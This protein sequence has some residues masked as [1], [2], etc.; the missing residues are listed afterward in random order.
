MAS[1]EVF[2][3]RSLVFVAA[4]V[5]VIASFAGGPAT[6]VRVVR[7]EDPPAVP[8]APAAPTADEIAAATAALKTALDADDSSNDSGDAATVEAIHGAAE[9]ADPAIVALLV[10]AMKDPSRAVESAAIEALGVND[11]ADALKAL[12]KKFKNDKALRDDETLFVTLLRAIGRHADDS[13]IAVLLEDPFDHLTLEVGR[14]RIMGLAG[15]RS[16]DAVKGLVSAMKLASP[17]ASRR[18]VGE[19]SE[20]FMGWGRAA[21]TILT[22]VDAGKTKAE[23]V[24]WWRKNDDKF[25]MSAAPPPVPAFARKEWEDFWGEPYKGGASERSVPPG[26]RKFVVDPPQADVDAAVA[27]LQSAVKEGDELAS[28]DAVRKVGLLLSPDAV[29]ALERLH[30]ARSTAVVAAALDAL[31]WMP[32][33]EAVKALNGLYR[34]ANKLRDDEYL[35]PVLLKAIGRHGDPS[36][37]EILT[38]KPLKNLTHASGTARILGLARIRDNDSVEGL[39]KA[40]MLGGNDSR[41]RAT[42]VGAPR[43]GSEFQLALSVLTGMEYGAVKLPW[44]NWWR[45]AKKTFKVA[46]ARPPIAPAL[47]AAWEEYWEE[48]YLSK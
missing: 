34:R 14:A 5:V 21:M 38:N 17:G 47:V 18:T 26:G 46:A 3:A 22:G 29:E 20:P 31:G 41:R 36:S 45:D 43:F 35:L 32:M 30:R 7:A 28:L 44:I 11:H 4:S 16:K 2:M 33:K 37:I 15:I 23:W 9:I 6:L 48:P 8:A 10:R 42:V 39:I 19:A 40:M 13:S 12:H 27:E 1:P 25:K 24:E